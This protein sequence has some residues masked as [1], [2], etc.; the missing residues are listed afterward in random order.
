MN[1]YFYVDFLFLLDYAFCQKY[2]PPPHTHTFFYSRIPLSQHVEVVVQLWCVKTQQINFCTEFFFQKAMDEKRHIFRNCMHINL[3]ENIIGMILK[4]INYGGTI[5][6]FQSPN[7]CKSFSTACHQHI[8][9]K[10]LSTGD[11]YRQNYTSIRQTGKNPPLYWN[12]SIHML[13][14]TATITILL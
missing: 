3:K 1:S 8:Q 4:K 2:N 13:S 10:G 11:I 6:N 5:W 7:C 9:Y 12:K 14:Y